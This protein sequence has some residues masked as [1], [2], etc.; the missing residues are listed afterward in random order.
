MTKVWV[1]RYRTAKGPGELV[2]VFSCYTLAALYCEERIREYVPSMPWGWQY[3][4]TDH[5]LD[6]R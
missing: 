4:I 3:I 1:V 2:G 6:P 5:E